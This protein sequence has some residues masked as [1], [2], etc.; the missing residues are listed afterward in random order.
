MWEGARKCM[1]LDVLSS[2]H[3]VLKF[4][5]VANSSFYAISL[6]GVYSDTKF[7]IRLA[8][9]QH[10]LDF[11]WGK[12]EKAI[13]SSFMIVLQPNTFA[14]MQWYYQS[15]SDFYKQALVLPFIYN[16]NQIQIRQITFIKYFK[17]IV[18]FSTTESSG[19]PT[20]VDENCNRE[21]WNCRSDNFWKA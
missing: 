12:G 10:T 20:F 19:P 18:I 8:V 9:T 2:K 6:S 1:Y 11:I 21:L 5:W 7:Q 13:C 3:D 17:T 4:F 16:M 15:R 14:D